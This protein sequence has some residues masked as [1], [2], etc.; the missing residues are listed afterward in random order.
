MVEVS[1]LYLCFISRK[2]LERLWEILACFGCTLASL[3]SV[4]R[5]CYFGF[6]LLHQVGKCSFD[7]LF[8][9]W[10]HSAIYP[11]FL[12][13]RKKTFFIDFLMLWFFFL[14][15]CFSVFSEL[16]VWAVLLL[17]WEAVCCD[18]ME[19]TK[20][21]KHLRKYILNTCHSC[22]SEGL[23]DWDGAVFCHLSDQYSLLSAKTFWRSGV[24]MQS[25]E[26]AG[27]H[28]ATYSLTDHFY[29]WSLWAPTD[30]C[31]MSCKITEFLQ[32]LF[33]TDTVVS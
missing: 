10:I 23:K 17:I 29:Q 24:W 9:I 15:R 27:L 18:P 28:Y 4:F 3:R 14:T 19:Q 13:R 6:S 26:K 8:I 2:L 20:K 5:L 1:D 7:G 11:F 33:C 25:F 16:R 31:K 22:R 21:K 12:S 32:F 30:Q